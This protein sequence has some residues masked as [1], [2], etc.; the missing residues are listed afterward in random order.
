MNKKGIMLHFILSLL[1]AI[2]FFA[3]G[4]GVVQKVF[5]TSEQALQ[6]FV[7]FNEEIK[8]FSKGNKEKTSFIMTLDANTAVVLFNDNQRKFVYKTEYLE[9]ITP[10]PGVTIEVNY[11]TENYLPYPT[12][13][14]EGKA[15]I[16]L[17]R[18]FKKTFTP[19]EKDFSRENIKADRNC[20]RLVC[21]N[22]PETFSYK[23]ASFYRASK[24]DPRREVV[25]L[26][27]ENGVISVTKK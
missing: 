20:E 15:C 9:S 3:V 5:S 23:D 19:F 26:S 13:I 8:D 25:G 1:V 22:L 7:E 27:K 2:L 11:K 24:N 17:C 18:E 16:C 21:Q 14:C 10:Q 4:F 12:K 6:N